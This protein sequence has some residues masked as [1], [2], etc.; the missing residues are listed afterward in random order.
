MFNFKANSYD[1]VDHQYLTSFK[2]L[3][4]FKIEEMITSEPYLLVREYSN[5]KFNVLLPKDYTFNSQY[6]IFNSK[7]NDYIQFNEE[8][9]LNFKN[10]GW[11]KE[12]IFNTLRSQPMSKYL[13]RNDKNR[14]P[15]MPGI[16]ARKLT[17]MI[18]FAALIF[19]LF[20]NWVALPW[21]NEYIG[22]KTK[23]TTTAEVGEF[24]KTSYIITMDNDVL[25]N[26]YSRKETGDWKKL[27]S[28][29]DVS[30]I[31]CS[32]PETR[33][34]YLLIINNINS[35]E[36]I[37]CAGKGVIETITYPNFSTAVSDFLPENVLSKLNL[38]PSKIITYEE[39]IKKITADLEIDE[40]SYVVHKNG[41]IVTKQEL[42]SRQLSLIALSLL[43]ILFGI[44]LIFRQI[45]FKKW[46]NTLKL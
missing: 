41:N 34:S 44:F 15:N 38:E 40:P 8:Y 12:K 33:I 39:G 13:S 9:Y 29:V 10:N 28:P 36:E 26:E 30:Y 7:I 5:P 19:V 17:Y 45:K 23:T 37:N 21:N 46:F 4:K 25:Y 11:T 32:V 35:K 14:F 20:F 27:K 31:L 6:Y 22:D 43:P 3:S 1:I 16:I 2:N 42:A 18:A 24:D